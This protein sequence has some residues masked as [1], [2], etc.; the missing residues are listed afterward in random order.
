MGLAGMALAHSCRIAQLLTLAIPSAKGVGRVHIGYLV[1]DLND[2]AVLR[3]ARMFEI[4][5]ARVTLAGFSREERLHPAIDKRS[6]LLLG[7]S[8]DA[9]LLQ[10]SALA[11]KHAL[12]SRLIRRHFESCDIIVARNLE[13]LAIASR[14]AGNRPLVYECL[15]IHRLLLGSSVP[16]RTVQALEAALLPRCDLLITSSP[17]FIAH[18]FDHRPLQAPIE[19]VENKLLIDPQ[20]PAPTPSAPPALPQGEGPITIGWFGMLRCRRT[21][22]FLEDLVASSRGAIEVLIAGKPS[23][24]ELPDL[25]ERVRNRPGITFHGAYTYDDL[26]ELYGR[27][28]FAWSIDWFEDGLNS[29]WLLPNRL[30]EALAHGCVPVAL[31]NVEV[32]RWLAANGVGLVLEDAQDARA[33]L[34]AMTKA[35]AT[36]LAREVSQINAAKTTA[37]AADC[38]A[39]VARLAGLARK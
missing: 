5:S 18:H 24:A 28:H 6:P 13:Q 20:S 31:K 9:A 30:Y 33:R 22:A 4:G 17:A 2:A 27:C 29:A 26:P 34:L 7:Q 23:R 14:V 11:L 21:L 8:H 25:A 10:R 39:L 15:D 38:E 12:L 32:G 16:A 36:Q 3:R 1:H 19:L 35:K 37:R